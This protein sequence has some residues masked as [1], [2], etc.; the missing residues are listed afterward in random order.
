V[1]LSTVSPVLRYIACFMHLLV[2]P[3]VLSSIV[4]RYFVLHTSHRPFRLPTYS[5]SYDLHIRTRPWRYLTLAFCFNFG[6]YLL[7][8]LSHLDF[9]FALS[10]YGIYLYSNKRILYY[11][12]LRHGSLQDCRSG[13]ATNFAEGIRISEIDCFMFFYNRL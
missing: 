12:K 5:V 6:R 13:R 11:G 3:L 8:L 7:N 9:V 1:P 2:R 4:C 10:V